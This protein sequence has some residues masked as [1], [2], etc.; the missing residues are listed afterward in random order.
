VIDLDLSFP[1]YVAARKGAASA[2]AREGAQYAYGGDLRVRSALDKVR[3]VTLAVEA[4]LR[5]WHTVGKNRL[6]GSSVRVSDRQ[7]AHIEKLVQKCA[8]TLQVKTP[9]VY[10]SPKPGEVVR[11]LGSADDATIVLPAALVDGFSHQELTFVIGRECGHVQNGHTIYL[12]ALYFLTTAA[13]MFVRWGAQPAVLA[14]NGWSRRAEITADRAGLLCARDLQVGTAVLVKLAIGGGNL[15]TGINLDEYL[16][17]LVEGQSGPSR[18]DELFSTYPYL[19]KRV[20]ALRLFA[21]TTYYRSV[22]GT[23]PS[24][25]APGLS[26]EECDAKVGELLAVFR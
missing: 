10:V 12:T 18:F 22:L 26:K 24:E 19:P 20:Q 14:L 21:E 7:F 15:Y 25:G 11:T 3:P 23:A 5:F 17:Q 2:R 9:T 16:Q 4:T 13:N 8:D 6:L 1:R